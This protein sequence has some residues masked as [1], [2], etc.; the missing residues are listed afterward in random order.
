MVAHGNIIPGFQ[1][2]STSTLLEYCTR[3]L[4]I[5][6]TDSKNPARSP[7][8][9]APRASSSS[10]SY[11]RLYAG[12]T[13]YSYLHQL[14]LL[15]Q[16]R[17][18]ATFHDRRLRQRTVSAQAHGHRDPIH[19]WLD[20][21]TAT[22]GGSQH[23]RQPATSGMPVNGRTTPQALAPL[24]LLLISVVTLLS[25][26]A[27][28]TLAG[29][30]PRR[31]PRHGS[32]SGQ[33]AA[34]GGLRAEWLVGASVDDAPPHRPP[35]ERCPLRQRQPAVQAA[36]VRLR[37]AT[38][39]PFDAVVREQADRA[40]ARGMTTDRWTAIPSPIAMALAA[41]RAVEACV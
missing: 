23:A 40:C 32:P 31:P 20:T 6:A 19:S 8:S 13:G 28:E 29:R 3:S 21:G 5:V 11:Y 33:A 15:P 38:A 7:S 27:A 18:L 24:L 41:G 2:F 1:I 36:Q 4:Y 9:A 17:A 39:P 26:G 37:L 34:L 30:L 14:T 16:A 25:G 12:R 10:S 35:L 22:S